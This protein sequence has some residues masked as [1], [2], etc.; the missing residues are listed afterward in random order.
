[1]I[2][3]INPQYI[4]FVFFFFS[5]PHSYPLTYIIPSIHIL[6]LITFFC[7]PFTHTYNCYLSDKISL[8]LHTSVPFK[9][10]VQ[11][12][13]IHFRTQ[14]CPFPLSYFVDNLFPAFLLYILEY[15]DTSA[16]EIDLPFDH[17][18]AVRSSEQ[19]AFF[20]YFSTIL[21]CLSHPH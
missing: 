16:T 9:Q 8:P 19:R 17:S 18:L 12:L 15:Q 20:P 7:I 3:L 13:T 11:P 21:S 10:A 5:H 2:D 14:T 1:M 4:L 6:V